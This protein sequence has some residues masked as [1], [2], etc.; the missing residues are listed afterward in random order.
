MFEF[1]KTVT[2]IIFS[3]GMFDIFINH[4]IST[5]LI[6]LISIGILALY[7]EK[8]IETGKNIKLFGGMMSWEKDEKL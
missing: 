3:V 6:T 7:L 4:Q 2:V 1:K 5:K 8:L